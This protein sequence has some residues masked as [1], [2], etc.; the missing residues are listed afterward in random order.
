LTLLQSR[1]RLPT[2]AVTTASAT[3]T[4]SDCVVVH[5][6]TMAS[7]TT[8]AFEC[9]ILHTVTTSPDCIAVRP[10]MAT[11]FVHSVVATA[12]DC[13]IVCPSKYMIVYAAKTNTKAGPAINECVNFYPSA[14]PTKFVSIAPPLSACICEGSTYMLANVI[15][16]V[17]C[18]FCDS[19]FDA[20]PNCA[21]PHLCHYLCG[22]YLCDKC[23]DFEEL[24]SHH[25]QCSGCGQ[26]TCHNYI[27]TIYYLNCWECNIPIC[28][29]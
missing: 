20:D 28:N 14:V 4:T 1:V 11:I 2:H 21:N 16:K 22:A 10:K 24:A 13:V 17:E 25:H 7:V 15:Y 9:I 18:Y 27:Q 19:F 12:S 29:S 6:V 8:M 23:H 5:P 26:H 3:A